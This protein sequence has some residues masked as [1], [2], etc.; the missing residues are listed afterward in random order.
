MELRVL[1]YFLVIAREQNITNAALK[2][3]ITQPTLSRQIK[4][5]EEEL[6]IKLL[7]RTNRNVTLTDEGI[8]LRKRAEEIVE[9][10]DK[11]LNDL[12]ASKDEI[13]GEIFI[14][15][16]ETDGIRNIIKIIKN[17]NKTY[18]DIK[19]NISSGDKID[20]SEKLDKGLIDFGIFLYPPD[21]E[22]Y[23]YLKIPSI[24]NFGILTKKDNILS[25]KTKITKKDIINMPLIISRQ[26]LSNLKFSDWFGNDLEKLNIVA[27]YN[28]AYNASIM[29]DEGIGNAIILDKIINTEN[30][31]L[32]FIPLD[33]PINSKIYIFWKKYQIFSKPA[34]LFLSEIEK[35]YSTKS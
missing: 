12:K 22:K 27:T 19:F 25:K 7:N 8:L 17:I 31:N 34:N 26:S 3:H 18:P 11:T 5:L 4:E 9:L 13:S 1:K 30:T 20:I 16:G 21:L 28:L 2:L 6:G 23:N 15:S 32:C 10:S 33:P 29:V 14:G 24:D 35:Y